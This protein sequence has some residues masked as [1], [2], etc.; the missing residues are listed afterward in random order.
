MCSM[1]EVMKLFCSFITFHSV[2]VAEDSNVHNMT[3]HLL[4]YV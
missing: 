2:S 3:P 4:A 1:S